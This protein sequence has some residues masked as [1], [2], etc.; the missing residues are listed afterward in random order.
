MIS[1]FIEKDHREWN[2]HLHEFRFAVNTAVHSSAGESPAVL[3]FGRAPRSV[4]S[5]RRAVE[6]E[7]LLSRRDPQ[8]WAQRSRRLLLLHDLVREQLERAHKRQAKYYNARHRDIKYRVGDLVWRRNRVLSS[9][10]ENVAAKLAAAYIG[11]FQ[12]KKVLSPV[13]YELETTGT[14]MVPKVHVSDLKPFVG[15][16]PDDGPPLTPP[17]EVLFKDAASRKE[18]RAGD[19]PQCS[20]APP[21]RTG[22]RP[23]APGG[24]PGAAAGP[25]GQPGIRGP[26][27]RRHP[28]GQRGTEGA[29]EE[30]PIQEG[31]ATR[32]SARL[33]AQEAKKVPGVEHPRKGSGAPPHSSTATHGAPGSGSPAGEAPPPRGRG[34]KRGRPR[35][36]RPRD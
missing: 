15:D 23:P 31:P 3:N 19:I 20:G 22:I 26:A 4:G 21:P 7:P 32:R 25:R 10:A 8:A 30:A 5:I 18:G 17:N 29:E 2:V 24:V 34:A 28:R 6:G 27:R 9:A 35:G 13:V 16:D 33:H 12:I 36:R 11:P 14:R 1:S